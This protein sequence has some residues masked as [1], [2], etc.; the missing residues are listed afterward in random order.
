MI[1]VWSPKHQFPLCMVL[2][3]GQK[4]LMHWYAK[5]RGFAD[6]G[7]DPIADMPDTKRDHP[8]G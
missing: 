8:Q 1:V 5:K 7:Y 4:F 6:D 3:Q 2:L